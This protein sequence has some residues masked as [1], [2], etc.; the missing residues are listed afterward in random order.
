MLKRNRQ[1]FMNFIKGV[2][3]MILIAAIAVPA[4]S[5]ATCSNATL[6][7]VYGTVE[8]GLNGSLE[9]SASITQLS[10]DGAGNMTGTVTKSSDGTI[11]T[12]TS[13]GTYQVNSN[14]TGTLTGT[15]QD[16]VDEHVDFYL[17]SSNK[18]GFSIKTDA[19]RVQSGVFAAQGTAT[20]TDKAVKKTYSMEL[21]GIDISV[22][23]VALAGQLKLNGTGSI[24]GTATLSLYGTI[25]NS[26][27]VTGTYTINSNCTGTAQFTPQG[28]SAINL[29][30]VVVD[31]DKEMF[32][33]ETDTN[34]IVSGTLL[35]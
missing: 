26:L 18:G 16:G 23:Q 35:E 11:I 8:S 9:P 12:Y 25:Y 17:N 19:P 14:C 5:A 4:A 13:T 32:A 30:L 33:V 27:S 15:N 6:N 24:S 28:L 21:A 34:T 10:L 20:C 1:M 3:F 7:G 22:G 29:S 31:A 2:L